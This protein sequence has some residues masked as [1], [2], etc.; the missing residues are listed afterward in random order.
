[1]RAAITV[2]QSRE[3]VEHRWH[4]EPPPEFDGFDAVV[5]F[6]QA[7]VDR[8]TEIHVEITDKPPAGKLGE[9]VR[10]VA[11][12]DPVAKAKDG[13]RHFKQLMEIGE[14]VRSEGAPEGERLER[15]LKQRPAQHLS[16]DE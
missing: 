1:M 5:T 16:E 10:K 3:D 9:A 4:A 7:P 14:I 15:K 12:T 2:N 8:G 13:L 6:Q 11:G